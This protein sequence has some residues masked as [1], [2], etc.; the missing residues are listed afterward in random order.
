MSV[1]YHPDKANVVADAL[2]CM[3]VGRVSHLDEAKNDVAREVHRL[4]RSGGE[5]REFSGC[6]FLSSL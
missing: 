1:L 5:V 4:A 2:S 6:G 3:T